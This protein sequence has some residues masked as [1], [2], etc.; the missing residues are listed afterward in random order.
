MSIYDDT[1]SIFM[2]RTFWVNL[3]TTLVAVGTVVAETMGGVID[4]KV[5]SF[6]LLVVGIA[7]IWLRAITTKP[8]HIV[9]K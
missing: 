3:L 7:N 6:I 9:P 8:V 5:M 2:S 4:P 1:K